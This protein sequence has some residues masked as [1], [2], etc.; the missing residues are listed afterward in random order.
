MRKLKFTLIELLVVIAII[1]ILAAMLLPALNKAREKARASNCLGNLKQMGTVVSLYASDY[2]GYI[3]S[4]RNVSL[5]YGG[6]RYIMWYQSMSRYIDNDIFACASS[7]TTSQLKGPTG[8]YKWPTSNEAFMLSYSFNSLVLEYPEASWNLT[9]SRKL[10]ML[11]KPTLT[12]PIMCGVKLQTDTSF[13]GYETILPTGL[14]DGSAKR[15]QWVHGRSATVLFMDGHTETFR[16]GP[17]D[18]YENSYIWGIRD[19]DRSKWNW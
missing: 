17:R 4:G 8:D 18:Q 15:Q 13:P 3:V 5:I 12:I 6:V 9:K 10:G 19:S 11:R 2:E 1:A 16:Q 7:T 14:A